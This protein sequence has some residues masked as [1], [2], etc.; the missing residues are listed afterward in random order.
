MNTVIWVKKKER[1]REGERERE[2]AKL[3]L[4]RYV[5]VRVTASIIPNENMAVENK[6]IF[7]Q[8]LMFSIIDILIFTLF[9]ASACHL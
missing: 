6:Y 3:K 7:T 8:N 1:K 4:S 2:Y 9:S 5:V